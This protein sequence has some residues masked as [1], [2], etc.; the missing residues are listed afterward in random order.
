MNKIAVCAAGE[1]LSS[2]VDGRFGRCAYLILWDEDNKSFKSIP[3]Q[4]AQR[5]HGSGTSTAQLLV[6]EGVKRLLV[7]RIGPKAFEVINKGGIKVYKAE[8][9]QT[10]QTVLD[11]CLQGD[12]EEIIKPNN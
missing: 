6:S 12:L 3:N 9:G 10:V 1:A 4:A 8:E 11:A 7:G 5:A 2:N